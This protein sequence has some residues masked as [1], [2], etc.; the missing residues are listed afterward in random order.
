MLR[1]AGAKIS[2]CNTQINR[3]TRRPTGAAAR[4][5][6]AGRGRPDEGTESTSTDRPAGRT[7]EGSPE[8]DGQKGGR[9][10]T[11]GGSLA[12]G[13]RERSPTAGA[14]PETP[15]G[16]RG[17]HPRRGD[18][19]SGEPAP[20]ATGARSNCASLGG[21]TT[22]VRAAWASQ[23]GALQKHGKGREPRSRGAT[24]RATMRTGPGGAGAP[25]PPRE[26]PDC[27]PAKSGTQADVRAS[28]P[29]S[30]VSPSPASPATRCATTGP[31]RGHRQRARRCE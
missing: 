12:R 15:R 19:G 8:P 26:Q 23:Q 27:P 16:A 30:A 20:G 7:G 2:A 28:A 21:S 6:R 25:A 4:A 13:I 18:K 22:T 5:P 3:L 1:A 17:P 31:S 9:G 10:G 29:R 14:Q 11:P 24:A